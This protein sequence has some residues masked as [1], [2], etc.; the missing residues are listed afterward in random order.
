MAGLSGGKLAPMKMLRCFA[1]MALS[2]A[3]TLAAAQV[4]VEGA[5]VRPTVAGQQGGGGFVTLTSAGADRLV[6]GS[7]AVAQRFELHS[8]AMKGDVMQMRQVDAIE[9]P[10]GKPVKLEPGGLHV[11][12][13]GLKQPLAI[14]SKVPVTL[15]FE[16]AGE[17]KVEFEV[18][19]RPTAPHKH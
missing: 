9:L 2:F 18:A 11:M 12:F 19:S 7:T 16:K 13:I 3:A 10:A 17:V 15:K 4:K 1:L 14:G 6:G 5:W 8:M